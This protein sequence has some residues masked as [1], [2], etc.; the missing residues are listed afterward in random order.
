M[1]PIRDFFPFYF[2]FKD[3]LQELDDSD[4]LA[5]YEG[6][7]NYAFYKQEPTLK[8]P[9]ARACWKLI[10]PL[11][12]KSQRNFENG[13]KGGAPKGSR[14]N[15]NGR[16]GNSKR[17]NRELTEELTE[18]NHDFSN[19]EIDIEKENEKEKKNERNYYPFKQFWSLY[20]IQVGK[21]EA[22]AMWN[23]LT[24]AEKESVMEYIPKY[25]AAYPDK[26]Y[27]RHPAKFL[28][29]R[30]WE[31][32]L[33]FREKE[34]GI[35]SGVIPKEGFTWYVGPT[36]SELAREAKE[37]CLSEMPL[38]DGGKGAD[39]EIYDDFSEIFK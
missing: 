2:S 14:N 13:S 1:K 4:R 9:I 38:P 23:N 35:N 17:T 18:T 33:I 26:Q 10:Q 24:I 30:T 6:I 21:Q 34:V 16:R 11:L 19:K 15:P 36:R 25:K 27:R 5:I 22:S 3:A 7:T 28:K 37:R 20:D 8:T 12:E 31:D 32:E 39:E 29:E